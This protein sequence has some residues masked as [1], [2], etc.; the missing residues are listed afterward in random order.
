M[1]GPLVFEW[2]LIDYNGGPYMSQNVSNDFH[3]FTL[4]AETVDFHFRPGIDEN[5]P[6]IAD[7]HRNVRLWTSA[8]NLV[9]AIFGLFWSISGR[10]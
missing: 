3:S 4:F 9:Q 1:C 5:R 6:K 8:L 10:K 7:F 2:L